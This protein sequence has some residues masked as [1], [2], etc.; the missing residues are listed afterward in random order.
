M[1]SRRPESQKDTR[2]LLTG[3]VGSLAEDHFVLGRRGARIY[4]GLV[5]LAPLLKVGD[6]VMVVTRRVRAKNVAE[7][8][9]HVGP[10]RVTRRVPAQE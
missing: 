2:V 9:T 3:T 8:I 6:M 5:N 10:S 1:G 4:F 7:Q